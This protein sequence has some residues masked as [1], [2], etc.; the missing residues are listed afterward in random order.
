MSEEV[1]SVLERLKEINAS[2]GENIF[3]PSLGKKAKFTPFTLKQQKDLLSKLPD[4]SS[5]VLSFNNNFNSI[6]MDNCMEKISLDDLNSFDRL[7]VVMQ[8]RISAVGGVLD[9]NEKK[10]DLNM[11]TKS[12]ESA[13][14]EKVFQEKE[15]KNA[16]FKATLKIPTLGYDQKINVST[17]FKLKKAGKQQEIIAEMFVAEVLKYITSIT[18]LDGPDIT[19]D[20]YQSSY[21][22]KIKVIEQLPNNFTKKIFAFISTVKLFEETLTT[23]EDIKI[24]ISNEL[25][26]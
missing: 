11:L 20:M 3:L 10:L 15:I 19:M 13:K 1:K 23:I 6:I 17:T 24:D 2:K 14:Y 18:I 25:F 9:K 12:I 8:Y 26:G 7:S 5:G 4:D 22:E 21:D 16:N